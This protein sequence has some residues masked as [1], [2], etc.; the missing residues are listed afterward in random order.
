[1]AEKTN[2]IFSKDSIPIEDHQKKSFNLR[3]KMKINIIDYDLNHVQEIETDDASALISYN[4]SKTVSWINLNTVKNIKLIKEI[5]N[6]FTL[7][8][9][10]LEDIVD[11]KQRSKIKDFGDTQFIV[12]KMLYFNQENKT[13][14]IE[15]VSI[16][17]G[18]NFV[19]S[20]QEKKG[21]VFDSIREKIRNNIG[22]I[23]KAGTDYLVYSLIDSVIDNYFVTVEKIGEEIEKLEDKMVK[24]PIPAN[25]RLVYKLKR[26]LVFLRKSV[27][28]LRE[29][30]NHMQLGE[31]KLIQ[32]ETI[33]YLR[34]VYGHA[35]H[36]IDNV[37]TLREIISGV[38][39]LYLSGTSNRMNEIM[40]VLTIIATIFI[41][42]TFITGIYGMNFK[43]MPEINWYWGYP[44]ILSVMFLLGVVMLVIFKRKKWL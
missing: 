28:P 31:S 34:D 42:L 19:I 26:D 44:F 7:H 17:L 22:H 15:Q 6:K 37:E 5:E 30:V 32:K 8:P 12:F 43:F 24:H 14:S 33:P 29:V 3:E 16:V 40:K 36:V 1:M 9:L 38:L 27:W 21:D 35:I 4:S 25:L 41:P 11:V 18:K 23:R 13:I 2:I 10:I 20:F 39:E